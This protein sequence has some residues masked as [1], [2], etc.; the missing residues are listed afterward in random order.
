MIPIE[1]EGQMDILNPSPG[2][3]EFVHPLPYQKAII[4]GRPYVVT[5]YQLNKEEMEMMNQTGKLYVSFLGYTIP[6]V[7]LTVEH[8]L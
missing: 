1:F 7:L 6:P 4:D 2:T 5:C 8:P 3:E